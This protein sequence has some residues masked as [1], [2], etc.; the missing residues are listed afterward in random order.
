MTEYPRLLFVTP[1]AFNHVTGG[2]VAFTNLFR[3]WPQD[4]IATVHN[5]PEPTAD[6][7]C[8]HYYR[9]GPAELDLVEPFASARRLIRGDAATTP[10]NGSHGAATA[11]RGGLKA[12]AKRIA[13]DMLGPAFPERA[14]LTPALEK[15][16][17]DFRPDVLYTILGS[18]GMMALIEK[19][20]ARFDL[21][22]VIHIMDDW[23][24][25]AHRQ[26]LLAGRERRV[27]EGHLERLLSRASECLAISSAMAEAYARRYGRPFRAFQ[28]AID[29]ARWAH[30][31]KRD[32]SVRQPAELLYVGSIFPNAQL[33]SLADC[34]EAVASLNSGGYPIKLSISTPS[35]H[36]DRYRSRLAIHPAIAIED[37]IRDDARFFARIAA[38]DALL[39]PVNFDADSLR[40]IRYSMPA[41]LPA[42]MTSGTPILVYGDPAA[43]QVQYAETAGWGYV[44]GARD[45]GLLTR[46][47]R[48][49]MEDDALRRHVSTAAAEAL[50]RHHDASTVRADFHATLAR[51]AGCGVALPAR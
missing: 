44:V 41:K 2:G 15:W 39:I 51:A 6:D 36:A 40:F 4:R 38:A 28:N 22:V 3:G 10:E 1:H 11:P 27:M 48:A 30:T 12:A 25:A 35:G 19:I 50:R 42:Y 34:A 7:V 47:I 46:G 32:L 29:V 49:I 31:A 16:I 37:T 43:A 21:P 24:A 20:L 5:D 33:D 14:A 23:P 45:R 17:G 26:G 9:L 13:I 18:N 8:R